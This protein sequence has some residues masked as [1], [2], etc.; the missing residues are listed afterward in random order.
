MKI[1]LFANTFEYFSLRI[2]FLKKLRNNGFDIYLLGT[3]DKF[4]KNFEDLGFNTISLKIKRKSKKFLIELITLFKIYKVFKEIKPDVIL[5]FTIKPVVYCGVLN[6]L[7]KLPVIN[8][9]TGVGPYFFNK[10]IFNFFMKILFKFSQKKISRVAFQNYDDK[11]FFIKNRLVNNDQSFVVPGFGVDKKYFNY[12]SYPKN[13][14]ITFLLIARMLWNK[15]IAEYVEAAE[16]I[17]QDIPNLDFQLLGPIDED[18]EYVITKE[19]LDVWVNENIINYLGFVDD[20]RPYILKSN[21]VVLPSYREG[22]PRSLL[23][24]CSMGRPIIASDAPGC[25]DIVENNINGFVCKSK[26][27]SDL[28]NKI[29]NFINLNQIE[30]EKMGLNG[31]ELIEKRFDENIIFKSYLDEIN[32]IVKYS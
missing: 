30:K 21:C 32:S 7:F 28:A 24:A 20:V 9:M 16:K 19:Q 11:N 14:K 5:N 8:T 1:I 23:Q 10:G 17:K 27:S 4:K 15:G 3:T 18:N 25:R 31:R 13:K 6:Y 29:I 2:N 22:M 26:D 12:C